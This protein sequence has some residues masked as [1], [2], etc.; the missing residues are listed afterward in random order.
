VESAA[1]NTGDEL[2]KGTIVGKYQITRPIGHG[3][4]GRVYEAV[5]VDLKKRVALKTLS[6]VL[7]TNEATVQRFMREGELATR[8]RHPHVVDIT[9]FGVHQGRPYLVM[10]LLE[11][12]DLLTYI[13]RAGALPV[14]QL[15]EIMLPVIAATGA[16]HD[17]GVIHR[18]LK[19][20]N[21][22]LARTQRGGTQPKLLDFGISKVDR[23]VSISE[24]TRADSLL[25]TPHYMSPEHV[26]DSKNID[27]RADQYALGVILYQLSTGRLPFHH[28]DVFS[29]LHQV[30]NEPFDPPRKL[31]P[32]LSPDLEKV[33]LR[34][35]SRKREERFA[36]VY[37]LGAALLP[38][39]SPAIRATWSSV[40]TA[41]IPPPSMPK[42]T[43]IGPKL[44][45]VERDDVVSAPTL[46]AFQGPGTPPTT[47]ALPTKSAP[48]R[49]SLAWAAIALGCALVGVTLWATTRSKPDATSGATV[50]STN[51]ST[52]PAA[53]TTT[54]PTVATPTA[55]A[56]AM[57]TGTASVPTSAASFATAAP[58][59]I[60]IVAPT[61]LATAP[62]KKTAAPPIA[63]STAPP[64]STI[65]KGANGATI[66]PD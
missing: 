28:D 23:G 35:M 62:P 58:S 55:T 61:A 31:R 57:A 46:E 45:G 21:V 41:S 65:K 64:M 1:P 10:E 3:G 32:D 5:H 12:E 18:D 9:D 2:A 27:T 44:Q 54:S 60:P 48:M 24:L 42:V 49:R 29:L 43:V 26:R 40:F 63:S 11:G 7:A 39:A 22:F 16:A 4:G 37:Q 59:V 33:I 14:E 19:P 34:A 6:A 66:I 20:S 56:A 51:G 38:F 50:T 8:I 13:N 25:G 52:T 47:A 17:V 30:V 15:L 53:S 36:S